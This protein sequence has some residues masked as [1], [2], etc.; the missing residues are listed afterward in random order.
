MKERKAFQSCSDVKTR[1]EHSQK[2]NPQTR[3][4]DDHSCGNAIK[5]LATHSQYIKGDHDQAGL[6]T[7]MQGWFHIRKSISVTH[8]I[9]RMENKHFMIASRDEEKVL[10]KTQHPIYKRKLS[11]HYKTHIGQ[12]IANITL[13]E[14]LSSFKL[15]SKTQISICSTTSPSES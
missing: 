6:T 8:C 1:Q 15:R 13:N 11:Q 2:K 3:V 9:H 4:S 12:F 14:K 7:E 10:S 5:A